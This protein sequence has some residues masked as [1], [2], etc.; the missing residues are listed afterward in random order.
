M[1]SQAV[2]LKVAASIAR[3]CTFRAEDDG[4]AGLCEE[5][6]IAVRG[7]SFEDAKRQM[8]AALQTYV[9]KVLRSRTDAKKIA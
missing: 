9:E 3:E 4:W 5:L 1:T 2:K 8:E 7:S 6:S